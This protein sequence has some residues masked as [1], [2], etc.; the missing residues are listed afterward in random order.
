MDQLPPAQV[1]WGLINTH[2]IAR[3]MHVIADFG[4]ADAL[5]DRPA[6]AAELAASTGMNADAL[7][8][9][10]RLLAAH[11]VFS[12][13]PPGYVHTPA[14]R[15]LR[16]DHPQ[17]MRSFARMIGMPVIWRGFTDLAHA[18][19]T[20]TPATDWAGL[21]AYF[22]D[23]PDE[24][25]LFNQAMVGKSGGVVPSVVEAYDFSPFGTVADVGGGRGHL[26]HAILE[27]FPT[28]SGI[29]FDLPHVIADASGVAS[30]RLR[31]VAGD[32]FRDLLPVADA[33]VLM[34]VIHDWADEEAA[35]ILSAVRR[36][37]PKHARVL[38]VE[39]FVSESPG[40]HFGKM[41]D[42]IMLAVTGGRERTRSEYEGLLASTGFRLEGIIPT[43]SQYSV[44]EAVVV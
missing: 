21:M 35:K 36:V 28:A 19:K 24:A 7:D 41:L 18:A 30:R 27:R 39:A 37:A 25:S 42:I 29:L 11:G 10:L 16:S 8:R 2:T 38:I 26:L 32:F 14:S 13:E 9:M 44:A 4:V 3:C 12:C 33:Y 5:G 23:H 15:L 22:S 6:S 40:P 43:P 17:S 20:G 34:E 1:V 31:L